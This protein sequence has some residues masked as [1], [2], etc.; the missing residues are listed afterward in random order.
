MMDNEKES[1]T[2]KLCKNHENLQHMNEYT[3]YGLG[4]SKKW[5]IVASKVLPTNNFEKKLLMFRRNEYDP[6]DY[7]SYG[8]Y[9]STT[10]YRSSVVLDTYRVT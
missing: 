1:E 10:G 3:E 8:I 2:E 4:K 6:T 5:H 9:G 7:M